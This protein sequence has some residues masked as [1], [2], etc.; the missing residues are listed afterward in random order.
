MASLSQPVKRLVAFKKVKVDAQKQYKLIINIP[1]YK[2]K[3]FNNK[4][5]AVFEKGTFNIYVGRNVHDCIKLSC[6]YI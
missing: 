2:L 5:D 3:F 4:G 1:S 6:E